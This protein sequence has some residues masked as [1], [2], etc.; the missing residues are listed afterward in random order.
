MLDRIFQI[1]SAECAV[2]VQRGQVRGQDNQSIPGGMH[3][4]LQQPLRIQH[5]LLG[6][7]PGMTFLLQGLTATLPFPDQLFELKYLTALRGGPC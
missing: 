2:P 7:P 3:H 1:K 6:L 4:A 5:H